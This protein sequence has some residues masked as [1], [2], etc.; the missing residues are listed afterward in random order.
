[1]RILEF[2]KSV[3]KK[4][5][6]VDLDSYAKLRAEQKELLEWLKQWPDNIYLKRDFLRV[7][8]KLRQWDQSV[9]VRCSGSNY[10][11]DFSKPC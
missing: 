4:P 2:I 11:S 6:K 3:F 9:P 10:K 7:S 8:D 5:V 1:M